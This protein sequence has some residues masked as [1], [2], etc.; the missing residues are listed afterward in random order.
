MVQRPPERSSKFIKSVNKIKILNW[1]DKAIV[2]SFYGLIYF[3]PI[4]IA[5]VE[6]FA[7][8]TLFFFFLKR[9]VILYHDFRDLLK[10]KRGKIPFGHK[11]G[12]IRNFFRPVANDLNRPMGFYIL[13]GIVSLL[14]STHH[15]LSVY[16]FFG[17]LL[18]GTYLYF[19]F[20]E[21]FKTKKELK[22]FVIIF[23]TSLTLISIDGIVQYWTGK[24]FIFGQPFEGRISASFRHANDLGAYLVVVSPL[25]LTV[26]LLGSFKVFGNNVS[27]QANSV[28]SFI[29]RAGLMIL[30][31]F[32]LGCM[33]LTY[34]RGAWFGF[35]LGLIFLG[36]RKKS[37]FFIV[38]VVIFSFIHLFY[39]KLKEARNV[40]LIA[41][42]AEL[43][44]EIN[45]I[46][47]ENLS[48]KI[49]PDKNI[50][51]IN[52][53]DNFRWDFGTGDFT[54]DYWYYPNNIQN[55]DGHFTVISDI[56]NCLYL[57][58]NGQ[59][60]L[61]LGL[62]INSKYHW[63]K[64]FFNT[65]RKDQ[66][67]HIAVVRDG[68]KILCFINGK[69]SVQ[70]QPADEDISFQKTVIGFWDVGDG[71]KGYADGYIYNFRISKGIARWTKDFNLDPLFEKLN[72]NIKYSPDRYI[73]KSAQQEDESETS[74]YLKATDQKDVLILS[75]TIPMVRKVLPPKPIDTAP[76]KAGHELKFNFPGGW[77]LKP[78]VNVLEIFGGS[79]RIVYWE[80]S[81]LMIR[82]Y[83]LF[84][85]GINAYS[86]VAPR[87]KITWGGYPHN[88]YLQMTVEI[89]LFGLFSF[90]WIIIIL[91][92][93]TVHHLN[94]IEDVFLRASLL[95]ISAGLLGFLAHSFFDT[96]FY[97][98]QL[99]NFMWVIMGFM[100]A[101][102]KISCVPSIQDER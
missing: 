78:V 54:I 79:G 93:R 55:N 44:H 87:Y 35:I 25:I 21:A 64:T 15:H 9:G 26:A 50:I 31:V 11:I 12:L 90:F 46:G 88:C 20:I 58:T 37:H 42:N 41:D 89:G 13:S 34:S 82:D 95:G 6:T 33:G 40:N 96:N 59:T 69:E 49:D 91:F 73:L 98:V 7:S 74:Y 70:I 102:Q 86:Q 76:E 1:F 5:L 60:A 84:G 17:K 80:E 100:V 56:G 22:I 85:V 63:F 2:Y 68:E 4:S 38:C 65:M 67:N 75:M 32:V 83:P 53:P 27:P 23:L 101:T 14:L 10:V 51:Q 19:T 71:N 48:M 94:R 52:V 43:F 62:K 45:H 66:W 36:F 8:F 18:Q 47:K 24:D 97:S 39:P 30:Y 81:L 77:L 16:G 57:R 99:G 29:V 61:E 28:G 3:T 92:N 72:K